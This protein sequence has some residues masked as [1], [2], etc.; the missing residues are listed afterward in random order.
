MR[1]N[2]LHR[3]GLVVLSVALSVA[4]WGCDDEPEEGEDGGSVVRGGMD[5]GADGGTEGG[6]TTGG[7]MTGGVMTGGVMTGGVMTGGVMTGGVMTGGTT[8]EVVMDETCEPLPAPSSGECSVTPAP[9]GQAQTLLVQAQILGQSGLI[10]NGSVLIDLGA[11]NGRILC[12]GCDC[13]A[14]TGDDTAR[15]VC[16]DSVLTPGLINPHDHLGWALNSP[17]LPEGNERYDHRHDWRKGKRQHNR[18]SAG[19]SNNGREAVLYGELRMLMGAATSIAGST[20]TDDL[21]RNLDSNSQNGGLGSASAD[22]RTFPLGDSDG[23]LIASGCDAYNIDN[24]SRL[25]SLVYLPHI[26]EGIDAEARNEFAC[27]SGEAGVDLIASNTSIIHGIGLTPSDIV[28]VA[29]DGA[30]LVWSPRSN[31]QLYGHTAPVV[32]YA[33]AGVNISLGTDWTPSGSMN[34]LRELRCADL[35]N[36]SYYGSF[37][38]DRQIWQMATR[39]AAISLG[40]GAQLGVIAEGFIADLALIHRQGRGAYRAVIDASPESI[41]LVLRGGEVLYGD[42]SLV[43]ALRDSCESLEVCGSSKEAC[44]Q[45]DAG[46]SLSAL[47]NG[48]QGAYPLFFCD[49]PDSE[50]SCV[51]FREG[52]FT[53]MSLPDDQDGD[54]VT[55]AEDNCPTVFNAPRPLEQ[56]TQGDADADGQGDACDVCPLNEGTDC[57]RFDPNDRDAD[58]VEDSMDNCQG[59]SNPDQLDADQDM[60]GDA[61]DPCPES[62][63]LNGAGCPSSIYEIKRSEAPGG[64]ISVEGVVTAVESRGF[65]MQV[66]EDHSDFAGVDD[67]GVYVYLGTGSALA[68]SVGQLVKASGE[69][70]E[71]YGQR[72]LASVSALEVL[73]DSQALPAHV[74]VTPAE[75]GTNGARATQLEGALVAVE[76]VDVTAVEL[77]AGPGDRDPTNEF[78]LDGSLAVNDLFYLLTPLPVVGDRFTR[79]QGVLRYAN[80]ASKL[81]PVG[82]EDISFVAMGP[83]T[84]LSVSP[85]TLSLSE[86]TSAQVTLRLDNPAEAP[87]TVNLSSDSD[88]VAVPTTALIPTGSRGV[89][90]TLEAVSV[91][92]ATIT[93]TSGDLTTSLSVSVVEVVTADGVVINE[94]DYD[95]PG[96]DSAEFIELYNASA[97]AVDLSLLRVEVINGAN[98]SRPANSFDL[99]TLSSSLAPGQFLVL[100]NAGVPVAQGALSAEIPA[101]FI[102]NGSPDGV[103]L[104]HTGTGEVVDAVSYEGE[105]TECVEGEALSVDAS[106]SSTVEGSIARCVDGADTDNNATDFTFTTSV[107]PG[108]SNVCN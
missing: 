71:Y 47:L 83:P 26:S 82:P 65:F 54:G 57:A 1:P 14:M 78:E 15:L 42:A 23:A 5:G 79:V 24:E 4:L 74:L 20:S 104:V 11:Q 16:P 49:T 18:I 9:S 108:S 95:Q 72:Q 45:G 102:Q 66:P 41:G 64:S 21:L 13:E 106:D 39:N 32:A 87:M 105:I 76:D 34:M 36:H 80:E 10:E 44:V 90:V 2:A 84:T 101:N 43:S 69:A 94:V 100:A 35:L 81:E 62:S 97:T 58:G 50:P 107:T 12:A 63:N 19:P 48:A 89:A 17:S 98:P 52:E 7:V 92:E 61:C 70:S 60:I 85:D 6:V 28:S 33:N 96:T 73:A 75:I 8:G 22:Y 53:G 38:T 37:F 25:N 88:A 93:A 31:I 103:R 99:S 77:P 29:Q 51:P 67:S 40:V 55:D 59:L 68:P 56:Y 3:W 86:G 30:S 46:V 91:G 27:L